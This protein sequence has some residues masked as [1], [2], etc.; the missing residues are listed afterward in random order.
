MFL[1]N[2]VNSKCN[3]SLSYKLEF[4]IHKHLDPAENAYNQ[5]FTYRIYKVPGQLIGMYFSDIALKSHNTTGNCAMPVILSFGLCFPLL[6][7]YHFQSPL[8]FF[9]SL[10]L[11]PFVNKVIHILQILNLHRQRC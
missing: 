6:Q 2:L 9:I 3:A 1:N 5:T 10:L 8:G 7:I 11:Q 4:I